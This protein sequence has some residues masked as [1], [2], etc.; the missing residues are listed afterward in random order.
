MANRLALIHNKFTLPLE[1]NWREQI[2]NELDYAVGYSDFY[3]GRTMTYG[4]PRNNNLKK[5]YPA[6]TYNEKTAT[7]D[8]EKY[9]EFDYVL[10]VTGEP[11]IENLHNGW[12]KFLKP[13]GAK[14]FFPKKYF[15]GEIFENNPDKNRF[16]RLFNFLDRENITAFY[17]ANDLVETDW[18]FDILDG[19]KV[20]TGCSHSRSIE[21][22]NGEADITRLNNFVLVSTI[23]ETFQDEYESNMTIGN[24]RTIEAL[25]K[26]LFYVKRNLF[27]FPIIGDNIGNYLWAYPPQENRNSEH[28]NIRAKSVGLSNEQEKWLFAKTFGYFPYFTPS[29]YN[30]GDAIVAYYKG[31]L[32]YSNQKDIDNEFIS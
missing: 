26:Y 1:Y 31:E 5:N 28:Y 10:D 32:I 12:V 14:V 18:N 22:D 4:T 30:L 2:T 25:K 9:K 16:S 11:I 8:Y 17:H 21:F 3:S 19:Y 13:F 29:K 23:D 6:T 15:T 24:F 7:Y 27:A 20:K